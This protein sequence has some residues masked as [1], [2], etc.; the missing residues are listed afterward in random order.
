MDHRLYSLQI[1]GL[2]LGV[3]NLKSI[4]TTQLWCNNYNSI[5]VF[6]LTKD[7]GLWLVGKPMD[8]FLFALIELS[9]LSITVPE[10]R[11]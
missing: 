7:L 8:D 1:L 10:L 11:Y 9:S 4:T 5:F 6:N 2:S 3:K